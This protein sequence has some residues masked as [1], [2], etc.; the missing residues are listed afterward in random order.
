[1]QINRLEQKIDDIYGFVE[2]C[3]MQHLS[4]TKVVVPKNELYDLLDDLR[5]D[6]PDEVH[7]VQKIV[8]QRDQ[9]LEDAKNRA[10]DMM[11]EAQEQYKA[12]V[13]EH[14]IMQEAYHQADLTVQNANEQAEQIIANAHAQAEEIGKGALYYT[15]DLLDMA[16]KTIQGA[17]ESSAH[18]ARLLE[19]TLQ[20]YLEVIRQNKAELVQDENPEPEVTEEAAEPVEPQQEESYEEE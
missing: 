13:E 5:R 3:K 11:Q 16:E 10:N 1:M 4:T 18:N 9:I 2:S 8:R 19:Q 14:A 15:N 6:I 7:R 12:M 20:N 17:Y